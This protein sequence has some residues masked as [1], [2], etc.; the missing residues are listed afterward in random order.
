MSLKGT[1]SIGL[2]AWFNDLNYD[3]VHAFTVGFVVWALYGFTTSEILMTAGIGLVLASIGQAKL[4]NK[5]LRYI[6]RE[7][8]YLQGG[9]VI[10]LLVGL[11]VG[12]LF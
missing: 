1:N 10:G 8:H 6:L 4:E 9:A 12:V 3:E 2:R 5:T 11:V 7:P